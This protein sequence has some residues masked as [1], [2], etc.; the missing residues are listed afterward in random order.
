[1]PGTQQGIA[2]LADTDK[3]NHDFVTCPFCGLHCDDLSVASNGGKLTVTKNGCEKA[4]AGFEHDVPSAVPQIGGKDATLP[5]AIAE[6]A[7]RLN[8]SRQPLIGGLGTD[9]EGMRAVLALA[10]RAGGVVDHALSAAMSRNMGV[11]QTK[12]WFMSTLTET[13][14]RA[15]LLIIV[16][17]DLAAEHPRFFERIAS[18]A[19]AM[20]DGDADKRTV[21]LIGC[22]G[23]AKSG[24]KGGRIGDVIEIACQ[25]EEIP[26]LLGALRAV[27]KDVPH[28]APPPAGIPAATLTDL[29]G[30][31][32]A[33]SYGVA[34]WAPHALT[35]ADADLA[36]QMVSDIVRDMN[37]TT[38]FVGLS[39][40]GNDGAQSAASVCSWQ[41]G[42]PLRVSFASGAPD[43]DPYRHDVARMLK[44][45]EGD[46]LV[47]ISSFGPVPVA[48][49]ET[50]LPMIV[51]GSPN[52]KLARAP[53]VFIPVGTPGL[54]HG[55]RLVRCDS[56]V[57]LPLKRL[58]STPLP[59]LT[60]VALNIEAALQRT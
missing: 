51:I 23:N 8:Q 15:D 37:K 33:A 48:P 21:V 60:E 25:A 56:V 22:G 46:L 34:V 17:V 55:G 41:T 16:G 27:L 11:L 38:R 43:Y 14:N 19:E 1:M 18:P 44:A 24:V 2:T 26:P 7:A 20:F 6:A 54:D 58:R 59:R 52:I 3:L 40:S 12:G 49:P 13:R 57:S 42:F 5:E 4:K 30:R 28:T 10:D 47:W 45:G 32:K 35:F 29:A 50:D 31:M 36:V 53:D 39:L 9:V